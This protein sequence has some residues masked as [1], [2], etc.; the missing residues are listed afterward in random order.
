MRFSIVLLIIASVA[1]NIDART[2]DNRDIVIENDQ[3]RFVIGEDGIAKSLLYK[4]TNEECLSQ[5]LNMPVFSVTQERPFHNE[6]K[7]AYPTNKITFNAKSV[8]KEGNELIVDFELIFY[9]ARIKLDIT[10]NYINFTVKDFF[11]EGNDYGIGVNKGILPP[12]YEMNFIQLPVRDR[13]HFGEWLNVSWDNKIAINVLATNIHARI[14]SEKREG[15][16]IMKAAVERDIQL[17]EVGAALIVCKTG[18]LLNNIARVEED[19]NLPKGVESR[20]DR[21]SVV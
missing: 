13:E 18:D 2:N 11:I 9:K 4:P 8:K 17:L 12:V 20:R 6:I 19:F 16:R 1:L 21:K 3:M 7:L 15:Y 10:P 14:N 5:Q